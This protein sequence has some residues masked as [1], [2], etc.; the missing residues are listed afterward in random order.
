[1]AATPRRTPLST[2][3]IFRLF[4]TIH[5]RRVALALG[6]YLSVYLNDA[7]SPPLLLA[8]VSQRCLTVVSGPNNNSRIEALAVFRNVI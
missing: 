1:M 6:T 5:E 4:A 2:M 8:S 3:S 7:G